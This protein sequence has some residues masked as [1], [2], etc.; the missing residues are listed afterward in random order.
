MWERQTWYTRAWGQ[1]WNSGFVMPGTAP[2]VLFCAMLSCSSLVQL[3]VT[4]W[5]VV[6][7]APLSMTFSRQECWSGLSCLT[8]GDLPDPGI[9]PESPASP[10][11]QADPFPLS[12]WGR[13]PLC[14]TLPGLSF[15]CASLSHVWVAGIPKANSKWCKVVFPTGLPRWLRQ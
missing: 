4:P 14:I 2:S 8:P 1:S 9:K 3:F 5:T 12:H 15:V 6:R 10:A 11:L 7:Q 13:P